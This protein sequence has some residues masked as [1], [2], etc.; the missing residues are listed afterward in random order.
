M[1]H[2]DQGLLGSHFVAR[3]K[4]LQDKLVEQEV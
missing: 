4:T 1:T 3:Q 2:V